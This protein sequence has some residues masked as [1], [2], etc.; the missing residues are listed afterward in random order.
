LYH[1]EFILLMITCCSWLISIFLALIY[2][3][4]WSRFCLSTGCLSLIVTSLMML[5]TGTVPVSLLL[6][7]VNEKVYFQLNTAA[8]WLLFFGSITSFLLSILN[9]TAK[10][11]SSQRFWLLG[12]T[13]SLFGALGVFGLQDAASFLIA[14]ELMSLGG[15][16]VIVG[17]NL[18][19]ETK[20]NT[21]L[22][23]ALLEVGAVAILLALIVL[24]VMSGSTEFSGF[25]AGAQHLPGIIQFFVGVL[26]LIGFGAKLGIL[27]FYEWFPGAYGS[28]SGASGALFS[29]IILNAGFFALMRSYLEW[30][31]MNMASFSLGILVSIVAVL[32]AILAI[33]YGF[34]QLDWR[35]LLS[36]SSAENASVAVLL[37]GAALLFREEHL[38]TL[39]TL[40]IITPLLHMAGHCLAKCTM[41]F[42]ADGVYTAVGSYEI[43]QTGLLKKKCLWG[44]GALFAAMSLSAIPPQIGFLSEWY[45]FQTFFQGFHLSNLA[46]RITL[47]FMGAGLALTSAIALATLVKLFGVGLLGAP[48]K[49]NLLLDKKYRLIILPLGLAVLALSIGMPW[50][51][52]ILNPITFQLFG[53]NAVHDLHVGWIMVPLTKSF[54]FTSPVMLSITIC[55]FALLPLGLLLTALRFPRR[56]EK[57]WF[58]G[59]EPVSMQKVATTALT[60][61]N[62]LRTFYSFLYHPSHKI[63]KNIEGSEYFVK[64]VKF[65]QEVSLFFQRILFNPIAK[66]FN[67]LADHVRRLQ[68]GDINFYNAIIGILLLLAMLSVVLF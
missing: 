19:T 18:S 5:L 66:G 28:G 14:W 20:A 1:L 52:D 55:I 62:A 47:V 49:P 35:R 57:V 50:W 38:Y 22:M 43:K 12:V 27:P 58:G 39:A 23:L 21:F 8:L 9:T 30:L 31:P 10:E 63:D 60:F 64:E 17:E 13:I 7:L 15:A 41:F 32:S 24:S 42:T 67:L 53:I 51:I 65:K 56:Y 3:L 2:Q 59:R 46:G 29:G 4:K 26:L 25:L 54:A 11:L 48:L 6:H 34:Q 45:A 16:V 44:I 68:S 33:L 61:S 37:L 36:L 40:A